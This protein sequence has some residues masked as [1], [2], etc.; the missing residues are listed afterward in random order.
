M[1]VAGIDPGGRGG[2]VIVEDGITVYA[3]RMPLKDGQPDVVALAELARTADVVRVEQQFGSRELGGDR[4][5]IN[6]GRIL[7]AL[8]MCGINPL[9]VSV[10]SWRHG[11][12][13]DRR[14]ENAK[15]GKRLTLERLLKHW[16]DCQH[17]EGVSHTPAGCRVAHDGILAAHAIARAG[18]VGVV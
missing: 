5:L 10:R 12:G 15:T 2:L 14:A 3:C 16:S 11:L 7:G 13:L 9:L 18:D 6:Y 4:R 1:R 8:E 17:A